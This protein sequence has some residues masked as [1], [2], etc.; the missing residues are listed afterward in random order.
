MWIIVCLALGGLNLYLYRITGTVIS[1]MI[2]SYCFGGSIILLI[3][4][5]LNYIIGKSNKRK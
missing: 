5:I 2:S 1:F 3:G 4:Y